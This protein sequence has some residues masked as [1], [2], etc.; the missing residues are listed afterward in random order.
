M[1]QMY[2]QLNDLL[3]GTNPGQFMVMNV[4]GTVLDPA[5]Y[6]YDTTGNKPAVVAANES[7][8]VDQLRDVETIV[9]G[10]NGQRVSSQYMRA[11]SVLIPKFD[12]MMPAIKK[13]MREY[14][15]SPAPADAKLGTETFSGSVQAYYFALYE[16][17]L[18]KKSEW[19]TLV[20][21]MRDQ[22]GPE[23]FLK[24]YEENAEVGLARIDAEEGRL[25]SVFSPTDMNAILGALAAGPGG[26][27]QAA[28]QTV[29]DLRLPSPDG[30]FIYPV[31]LTPDD[32][33]LDLASDLNPVDLLKDPAFIAINLSARRD[34]LNA[35]ISQMQ[36]LL[37][38]MPTSA[39]L[40]AAVT[41]F[42]TAQAAYS[43][44]QSSLQ[45][46]YTANTVTAATMVMSAETGG[47]DEAA[48]DDAVASVSKAAGVDST[49]VAAGTAALADGSAFGPDDLDKLA[50]GMT[51]VDSAQDLLLSSASALAGAGLTL[52]SDQA[53][54]F[55]AAPSLLARAQQ[56][57]ADI[58]TMQAQLQTPRPPAAALPQQTTPDADTMTAMNKVPALGDGYYGTL[59]D[60]MSKIKAA[61][62]T[63]TP[64]KLEPVQL[65]AFRGF[66]AAVADDIRTAVDS[67]DSAVASVV[68]GADQKRR[69]TDATGQEVQAQAKT[70]FATLQTD[71]RT[72]LA[73]FASSFQDAS[74]N[75]LTQPTDANEA[76]DQI[77]VAADVAVGTANP[78]VDTAE[79]F[80]ESLHANGYVFDATKATAA[81]ATAGSTP[82]GV[83]VT[84]GINKF[85]SDAMTASTT[86]QTS[87]QRSV[88]AGVAVAKSYTLAAASGAASTAKPAGTS[89]SWMDL[90][91]ST[92][93]AD[94][95]DQ[96]DD[97]SSSSQTS[98]K[99]DL[100]FGSASGSS[101]NSSASA[102][103]SSFAATDTIQ[104]GMKATRVE[105]DREWLDPGVFKLSQG[106][107]R[108]TAT[109]ISNGPADMT[110]KDSKKAAN[111]T[112]FPSFPVGL[113]I[114]K[115]V[116]LTFQSSESSLQA[117]QTVADSRSAT[118]GG[119]LCFSA[120]SSSASHNDSAS[121]TT[122]STESAMTIT[123]PGP[124]V[125]GW[126]H[127]FVPV[128]N[129]TAM[130]DAAPNDPELNIIEFVA[131]LREALPAPAPAPAA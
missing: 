99:V 7:R 96:S 54:T 4:P 68:Q 38:G 95:T 66:T 70:L 57:L 44:A 48:L 35:T 17:W 12:P 22:K 109:R 49:S 130:D 43:S 84:T 39:A 8:L 114:V 9:S 55:S 45:N 60:W 2:G 92:T 110:N 40:A 111:G 105:I 42:S 82:S 108:I 88:T 26:D 73:T 25:L 52:A 59:D 29:M 127:E 33:F 5:E 53:A 128:D 75:L 125:L 37:S 62:D 1:S 14:L 41:Q 56:Q 63:K 121:L 85:F 61:D 116:T 115:D 94:A 129:A 113:L 93:V 16:R 119:F 77:K 65:A 72:A 36:S 23:E 106:M 101:S 98:W 3:G 124:Q 15:N 87:I 18:A 76:Y 10:P 6:T 21:G 90:Q 79:A 46:A 27:V 120:S 20:I 107:S 102:A 32:W 80:A 117:L 24:W 97:S 126:F 74:G 81:A 131:R 100:F 91:F 123:I 11:L 89:D 47:A 71:T 64:G 28:T 69:T 31:E 50:K 34:A 118:G 78:W 67:F 13:R 51:A 19:E 122:H 104:I 103:K 30:G 86:S 83:D 58:Q 112:I